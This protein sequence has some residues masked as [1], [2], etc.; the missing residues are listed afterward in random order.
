MSN[1]AIQISALSKCYRIG[2]REKYPTVREVLVRAARSWASGR[3]HG[4]GPGWISA[5]RDVDLEVNH[6]EIPL[7]DEVLAVGDAAF[8][9]KSLGKMGDVAGEGRTVL[10]VS[11]NMNAI[12]KIC[13]KTVWLDAGRVEE[14]GPTPEVVHRY[15][16]VSLTKVKGFHTHR[17]R[18]FRALMLAA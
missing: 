6:G 4:N 5:L 11:H 10:F 17:I 12:E 16:E 14:I 3:N 9:K 13:Q 15:L 7:V 18:A 8:Q 1:L 2:V